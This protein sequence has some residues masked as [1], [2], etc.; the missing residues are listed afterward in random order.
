MGD[1]SRRAPQTPSSAT[2]EEGVID[3]DYRHFPSGNGSYDAW[4]GGWGRGRPEPN[5][6][7]TIDPEY[8]A[9]PCRNEG[10]TNIFFYARAT[11]LVPPPDL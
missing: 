3:A 9:L 10:K 4:D 1:H 8:H 2:E 11:L 7:K 5:Q 6:I